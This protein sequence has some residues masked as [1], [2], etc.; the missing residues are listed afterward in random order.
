MKFVIYKVQNGYLLNVISGKYSKS[1]VYNLKE[2]MT[3]FAFID[4]LCGE[5]PPGSVG[6][7]E[8]DDEDIN[9]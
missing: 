7:E 5:E 3:M 1:Y 9:D 6:M 2:R 4:K 8:E